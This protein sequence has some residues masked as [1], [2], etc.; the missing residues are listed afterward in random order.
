M[1]VLQCSLGN[2]AKRL[3]WGKHVLCSVFSIWSL[4]NEKDSDCLWWWRR[5]HWPQNSWWP[6]HSCLYLSRLFGPMSLLVNRVVTFDDLWL[7]AENTWHSVWFESS[8]IQISIC[9]LFNYSTV[10]TL[11]SLY[12]SSNEPKVWKRFSLS[13][14]FSPVLLPERVQRNDFAC[15]N[16]ELNRETFLCANRQDKYL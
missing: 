1:F 14:I 3:R 8:L 12:F 9:E 11:V 5:S 6:A 2:D 15:N 16:W 7:V 13:L 4:K 10:L